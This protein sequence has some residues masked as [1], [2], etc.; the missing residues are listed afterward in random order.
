LASLV[1]WHS[2]RCQQTADSPF[3][4]QLQQRPIPSAGAIHPIHVIL[5]V[6]G[7]G[8]S[9]YNSISH[10]L[11]ALDLPADWSA[12]LESKCN[13]LVA[14]EDGSLVLFVAEP[15]MTAAKYDEFE[16]LVWRDAGILQSAFAVVAA[17]ANCNLCLLGIT[18]NPWAAALDQQGQL[19]G[20]GVAILGAQGQN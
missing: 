5:S 8:W 2:S 20:V 1:L 11:E 12:T 7:L 19:T 15:G 14:I 10:S 18:G 17:A 6:P 16:S 13:E 9:R 4:F 3:G